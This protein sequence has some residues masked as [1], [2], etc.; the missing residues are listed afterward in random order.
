MSKRN[1]YEIFKPAWL[2]SFTLANIQGAFAK[3]GIWP[4]S[5]PVVLDTIKRRPETPLKAQDEP[6]KPPPTPMTSKSIR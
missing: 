1:F 4:F 3:T 5:P 6:L 2:E